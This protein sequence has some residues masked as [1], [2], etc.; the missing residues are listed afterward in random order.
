VVSH[1]LSYISIA[2]M[3]DKTRTISFLAHNK[4]GTWKTNSITFHHLEPDEVIRIKDIIERHQSLPHAPPPSRS[5]KI[6]S[7]RF[8]YELPDPFVDFLRKIKAA[9]ND[10]SKWIYIPSKYEMWRNSALVTLF[11]CLLTIWITIIIVLHF[12]VHHQA[13]R[14]FFANYILII[15]PAIGLLTWFYYNLLLGKVVTTVVLTEK[16]ILTMGYGL[17]FLI[18]NTYRTGLYFMVSIPIEQN[19]NIVHTKMD[20]K[21]GSGRLWVSSSTAPFAMPGPDVMTRA[22]IVFRKQFEMMAMSKN[23]TP[24]ASYTPPD[25]PIA[26]AAINDDVNV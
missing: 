8:Q 4:R 18:S 21:T 15:V 6:Q 14:H 12:I 5:L 25:S 10:D 19:M 23:L 2:S 20:V 7:P 24:S 3:Q 13:G 22:E 1:Y 17:W 26:G 11:F 16:H 9:R